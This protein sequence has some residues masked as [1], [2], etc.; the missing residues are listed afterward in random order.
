MVD[1]WILLLHY[2]LIKF[3]FE[4]SRYIV[5]EGEGK[6]DVGLN[7]Q[8]YYNAIFTKFNWLQRVA[9]L[10]VSFLFF[11]FKTFQ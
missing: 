7:P 5:W 11:L 6:V 9:L 2:Y 10:F 4:I 8:S 3:C 1:W